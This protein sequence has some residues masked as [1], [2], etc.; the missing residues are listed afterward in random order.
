MA[1]INSIR[2]ITEYPE[3][4]LTVIEPIRNS[5]GQVSSLTIVLDSESFTSLQVK[6][7]KSELLLSHIPVLTRIYTSQSE[8]LPPARTTI[9]LRATD[10]SHVTLKTSKINLDY[11]SSLDYILTKSRIKLKFIEDEFS[12]G[13]INKIHQILTPLF[14]PSSPHSL[15]VTFSPNFNPQICT[16]ILSLMSLEERLHHSIN[17][18]IPFRDDSMKQYQG[19]FVSNGEYVYTIVLGL[20]GVT[21]GVIGRAKKVYDEVGFGGVISKII[22]GGGATNL[23]VLGVAG[24]TGVVGYWDSRISFF[25][26]ILATTVESLKLIKVNKNDKLIEWIIWYLIMLNSCSRL[27]EVENLGVVILFNFMGGVGERWAV[28]VGGLGLRMLKGGGGGR[29]WAVWI[30]LWFNL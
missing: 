9:H 8:M 5:E 15:T 12:T 26:A 24:F 29:D 13:Y 19:R 7:F 18:Y 23:Y 14:L 25:T 20:I 27:F 11:L 17:L 3:S 16:Y 28:G 10:S 21:A 6:S 22:D 2:K 1:K 4:N 30:L